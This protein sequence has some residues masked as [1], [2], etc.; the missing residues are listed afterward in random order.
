MPRRGFYS[1]ED[2]TEAYIHDSEQGSEGGN[3]SRSHSRERAG[4]RTHGGRGRDRSHDRNRDRSR[5]RSRDSVDENTRPKSCVGR[6][7]GVPG[8]SVL[9]SDAEAVLARKVA[10]SVTEN[11][12]SQLQIMLAEKEGGSADMIKEV[13]ALRAAQHHSSLLSE[14]AELQS[15]SAQKQFVAFAKVKSG[16]GDARRLVLAGDTKGAE[17]A[18]SGVEKVADFRLD[19]IRRA[20]SLPGGWA[21]ANLYEK[22]VSGQTQADNRNDKIWR[23]AVEEANQTRKDKRKHSGSETQSQPFQGTL[24][25]ILIL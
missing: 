2:D 16:V 10:E 8:S 3:R 18:L 15:E 17:I 23:A 7:F 19:M 6:T 4:A 14:A 1:D 12:K 13:E 5:S 20:D 24:S 22:R 25:F 11:L 9:A 21:A